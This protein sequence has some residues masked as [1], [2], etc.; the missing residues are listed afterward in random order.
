M[1]DV[2]C[3]NSECS[4]FDVPKDNPLDY[5]AEAIVCGACGQPV[6]EA[7]APEPEPEP[8]PKT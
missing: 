2:V 3:T 7:T 4:E 5:P 8:E 6:S 1:A